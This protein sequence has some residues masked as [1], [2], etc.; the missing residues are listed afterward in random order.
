MGLD[1]KLRKG[2]YDPFLLPRKTLW[3]FG[4]KPDPMITRLPYYVVNDNWDNR[5]KYR[6]KWIVYVDGE[7]QSEGNI[8]FE[9]LQIF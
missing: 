3:V 1:E 2:T 8:P 9:S 5:R 6:V 7:L 4:G